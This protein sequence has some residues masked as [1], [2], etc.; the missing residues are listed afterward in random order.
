MAEPIKIGIL[1]SHEYSL[2]SSKKLEEYRCFCNTKNRIKT[3]EPKAKT[4]LEEI[5]LKLAKTFNLIYLN[6]LTPFVSTGKIFE[7]FIYF[8]FS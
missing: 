4:T 2:F 1:N 5:L 3:I 7:L 6:T 8:F